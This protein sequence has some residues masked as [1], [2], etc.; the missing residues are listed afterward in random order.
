MSAPRIYLDHAATTPVRPEVFEA[1]RPYLGEE[2]FGNPSSTHRDGR[3]ARAG[4]ERARRDTAEALGVEPA[5]IYFT[6]GGTEADNLAIIGRCLAAREAGEPMIA[7]VASTEHKAVLASAHA[8]VQ[9]GGREIILPVGPDGTL[10]LADLDRALAERPAV[11]SIMWVN[12]ETGVV[13]PVAEIA[14]RTRAAGSHFH[15][16]LV[17]AFGRVPVSIS[18]DDISLAT[19]SGHKLGAPKGIGALIVKRGVRLVP[20]IHGGGQQQ[21]LRPGTENIA[22]AVGLARAVQLARQEQAAESL[23]LGSMSAMLAARLRESVPDLVI[24]GESGHRAPH[25][26]SVLIPGATSEAMLIQLDQAGVAAS[27]GSACSSGAVDPSHV[28]AAMGIPRDLA[29]GAIRFSL[30]RGTTAQDLVRAAETVPGVVAKCRK[31]GEV[32]GRV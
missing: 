5:E 8:V 4:L 26:V 15:T 18:G 6:S 25:I 19:L 28:H 1:M 10:R 3:E 21:G 22:G 7:A 20:L 29:L 9:L 17:Q 30:G 14:R 24:A 31:L 12:N 13:Q 23:R 16:D 11:V 27:G 32:L 2:R